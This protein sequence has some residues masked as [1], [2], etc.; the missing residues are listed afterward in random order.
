MYSNLAYQILAYALENMTGTP[1]PELMKN[2]V[3]SPLSMSSTYY[4][5]AP[6]SATANAIIP[7]NASLSLYFVNLRAYNAGGAVYSTINDLRAFGKSVLKSSIVAP[8]LTRRWLQPH[9]FSPNSDFAVGAPWEIYSVPATSRFPTRLYTKSGSTGYYSTNMILIPGYDVGFTV[10]AAGAKTWDTIIAISDILAA[11][12][13]PAIKQVA[14]TQAKEAYAGTYSSSGDQAPGSNLRLSV[15]ANEGD[16]GSILRFDSLVYNGTDLLMLY[17]VILAAG[18][19][20]ELTLDGYPTGLEHR[21]GDTVVESWRAL[22]NTRDVGKATEVETGPFSSVC[23]AWAN[24]GQQVYGGVG[25]DEVLF[26]KEGGK[27]T[28]VEIRFLQKGSWA[29]N[30]QKDKRREE[31]VVRESLKLTKRKAVS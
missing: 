26:T 8:A 24:V 18:R 9:S 13:V 28:A 15:T 5:M 10:L 19:E 11:N 4:P 25:I 22:F 3:L 1:F 29:K 23:G 21:K 17:K 16:V 14:A 12:F 30:G 7:L 20:I 6:E 2:N 31:Q 27:V